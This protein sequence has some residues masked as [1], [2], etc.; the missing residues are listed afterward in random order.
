[1]T[2]FSII[3]TFFTKETSPPHFLA[4]PARAIPM[5]ARVAPPA[6]YDLLPWTMIASKI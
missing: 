3:K 6:R 4:K 2:V 1:M 5:G